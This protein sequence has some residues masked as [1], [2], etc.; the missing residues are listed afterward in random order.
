MIDIAG[1]NETSERERVGSL[2]LWYNCRDERRDYDLSD[3][4]RD[5][6]LRWMSVGGGVEEPGVG[7][8]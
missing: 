1:M 4:E 6:K 2:F 5:R 7:V 8:G 3:P